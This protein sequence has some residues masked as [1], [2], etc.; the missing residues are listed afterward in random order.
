MNFFPVKNVWRECLS[1]C[2]RMRRVCNEKK[3]AG[4][5][6]FIR[7]LFIVETFCHLANG[8]QQWNFVSERNSCRTRVVLLRIMFIKMSC[9]GFLG[10]FFRRRR[11]AMC[12][13]Q[14]PDVGPKTMAYIGCFLNRRNMI[15]SGRYLK[16]G[17]CFER[18]PL[19][20]SLSAQMV[21]RLV[22]ASRETAKIINFLCN[23]SGQ[24][25]HTWQI[26]DGR[27]KNEEEIFVKQAVHGGLN[28][29]MAR[30][31]LDMQWENLIRV[32]RVNGD[33]GYD[34]TMF[35]DEIFQLLSAKG[36]KVQRDCLMLF[37]LLNHFQLLSV[38]TLERKCQSLLHMRTWLSISGSCGEL[39]N[40][41]PGWRVLQF[42]LIADVS[43]VYN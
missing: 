33:G 31:M 41:L 40:G 39:M 24:I 26:D 12:E 1:W 5:L 6:Q 42:R 18:C 32:L 23:C 29:S 15:L 22:S 11:S 21:A 9:P 28:T 36:L 14:D 13:Q 25:V 17:G 3:I 19:L 8:G 30:D 2:I 7:L 27:V 4:L 35:A 20:W 43:D 10:V 34:F 38:P 16:R 37:V